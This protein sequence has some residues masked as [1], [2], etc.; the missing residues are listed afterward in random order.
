[1]FHFTIRDLFLVTLAAFAT[2]WWIDRNAHPAS[3]AHAEQLRGALS[4]S[5]L[6]T[7]VYVNKLNG[8]PL[9]CGTIFPVDWQLAENPMP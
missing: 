2:G 5:K 6:N 3:R 7:D 8:P 1:M 9:S 4:V